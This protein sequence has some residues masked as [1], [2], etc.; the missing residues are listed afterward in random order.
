[1]IV[2]G[3]LL[4]L[5]A[6]Y[7]VYPAVVIGLF[8]FLGY[9]IYNLV[10]HAQEMEKIRRITGALLPIVGL[11]FILVLTNQKDFNI[12]GFYNS[13]HNLGGLIIGL[14]IG[15]IPRFRLVVATRPYRETR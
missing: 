5:F 2:L 3:N 12:G 1:M 4:R 13:L 9:S 8:L 6:I 10:K 11:V 7:I 14:V 15:S